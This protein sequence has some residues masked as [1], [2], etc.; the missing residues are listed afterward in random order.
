MMVIELQVSQGPIAE[1][2]LVDGRTYLIPTEQCHFNT[3]A[4]TDGGYRLE[5]VDWI[6]PAAVG[7]ALNI[8]TSLEVGTA[9]TTNIATLGFIGKS[10]RFT[11]I[12][13]PSR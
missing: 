3:V 2:G 11:A 9:A 4:D 13:N 5:F 6:R 12:T 10:G 7:A 8:V 1:A